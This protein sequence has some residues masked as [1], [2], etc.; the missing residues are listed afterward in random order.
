MGTW[1][2]IA[3]ARALAPVVLVSSLL[4]LGTA[5]ALSSPVGSSPDD[6]FHLPSIWCSATAGSDLCRPIGPSDRDGYRWV[7]VPA[8][9]GPDVA[10]YRYQIFESAACQEFDPSGTVDTTSND[11]L[12]P[13]GYYAVMGILAGKNVIQSAVL[14]RIVNF[15]LCLGLIACAFF[16][17]QPSIRRIAMVGIGATS[18]P[19]IFF[20]WSSTN[21][22]GVSIAVAIST[23]IVLTSLSEELSKRKQV[24]GWTVVGL[25]SLLALTSRSD[26]GLFLLIVVGSVALSLPR[27]R[28]VR[29]ARSRVFVGLVGL[30]ILFVAFAIAARYP[31]SGPFVGMQKENYGRGFDEVFFYNFVNIPLLWTGPLGT[32]GLGWLDTEMPAF[33]PFI[34]VSLVVML[35]VHGLLAGARTTARSTAFVIGCLFVIPFYVMAAD[36]SLVGEIFQ[37]RYL[38]PLLPILVMSACSGSPRVDSGAVPR[39]VWIGGGVALALAHSI[40]LHANTRRYTTGVEY[41]TWNLDAPREWWWNWGPSPNFN[42]IVGSLAFVAA[43]WSANRLLGLSPTARRGAIRG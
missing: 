24:V 13:G 3:Q 26:A 33:V 6:D 41:R 20:L 36:R 21:P 9:L 23:W 4:C 8:A 16:V 37:S 29:I 43:C 34:T 10:C 31:D 7:E 40:S 38:L 30:A 12:Y 42:W 5:W 28:V 35:V 22:S 39:G 32:Q 2:R 25:G 14:M 17:A 11:G 27:D 15:A 1:R 19:M 18:V